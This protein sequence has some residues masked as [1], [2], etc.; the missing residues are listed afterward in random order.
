MSSTNL[1]TI[2]LPHRMLQNDNQEIMYE[3]F[4]VSTS[5]TIGISNRTPL[6]EQVNILSGVLSCNILQC[7]Q[8]RMKSTSYLIIRNKNLQNPLWPFIHVCEPASVVWM[9]ASQKQ[10]ILKSYAEVEFRK[11]QL[12]RF[13]T[14]N[15]WIEFSD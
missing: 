7:S 15:R 3:V 1:P 6:M 8:S 5:C 2:L 11:R 13:F 9:T 14:R 4:Y 12:M 10:K